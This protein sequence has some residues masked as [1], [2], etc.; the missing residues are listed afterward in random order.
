MNLSKISN[1]FLHEKI[2][3]LLTGLYNTL[4]GYC[5]FIVIFYYFSLT[6]NHSFLLLICHVI[7]TTHNFFTYKTF[8]FKLKGNI[9][10]NYFKFN[11]VYIFTF[12]L[13]LTMFKLLTQV[14][15]WN[16]YYSQALIVTVIAVVGYI[17]NKYYSFSN[18]SLFNKIK[19]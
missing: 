17:L 13:N 8:V 1:L 6:V 7:G 11:L 3:Y 9:F 5:I 10:R 2:K 12:L 16:L 4:F 19:L 18:K 15:G 14:M